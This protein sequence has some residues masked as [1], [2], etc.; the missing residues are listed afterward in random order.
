MADVTRAEIE[1]LIRY[2]RQ[3]QGHLPETATALRLAEAVIEAL[4]SPAPEAEIDS[5]DASDPDGEWSDAHAYHAGLK[6]GYREGERYT[7][8]RLVKDEEVAGGE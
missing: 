7:R 6:A 8:R 2:L 1:A 3:R 5:W 4:D